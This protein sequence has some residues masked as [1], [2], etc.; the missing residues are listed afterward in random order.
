MGTMIFNG[1][2]TR[3]LGLVIQSQPAYEFPEKEAETV[4]VP[5]RNGDVILPK[6][7]YS[8]V[9]RTYLLGMAFREST[10]FVVNA[11]A[12]VE[13]LHS[14]N[15]YARLEDSYE[16]E[17]YRL[18]MFKNSGSLS[19]YYDK[20]TAVEATFICK[21]QRFLKSGDEPVDIEKSTTWFEILNPTN[22]IA[23]PK[24]ILHF[25]STSGKGIVNFASSKGS[26]S[27]Q[28]TPTKTG[29]VTVDSDLQDAYSSDGFVNNYTQI[30]GGFPKLY[31][32]IT[33]IQCSGSVSGITVIPRWW[34]L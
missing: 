11:N 34:T 29:D 1:T 28:I 10:G 18:A 30:S 27:V 26:S 25:N 31:P 19:N 13:W 9:E 32:G 12:I 20:G 22:C 23:L 3:D 17:Y 16:P 4:H 6:E 21:P 7:S 8:N 15:G 14:A 5:G 24:I 33:R 2:S